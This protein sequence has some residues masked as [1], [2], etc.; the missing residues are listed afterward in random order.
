M[1][2]TTRRFR[3]PRGAAA[4]LACAWEATAPKPGNVHPGRD[5]ADVSYADFI[6][7]AV[8][9]GP[10][11][12]R[13]AEV[14]IGPTVL[15]AVRAT[16]EAVGTN[17]NLGTLLLLAPLAAVPD[18][19]PWTDGIGG[20][21]AR[22]TS[23]DTR[24][25][26]E[27]IRV[28]GAGGLG[29]AQ[30]ADVFGDVP[31]NLSLVEAMRLAADRD[32]VARQ[33]T[34]SFADVLAGPAAW[35]EEGVSRG[36]SLSA[37]IVQAHVRQLA[38]CG[39]SLI[40]RKCGLQTSEQARHR[41]AAVLAVGSPDDGAYERAVSELDVWLRADGHRRNPGTTADLLAAGLF[42]LLREGR[43]DWTKIAWL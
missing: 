13:A 6:S 19:V 8:V 4:T 33:Y 10:I 35:I 16:R 36:W 3:I 42:V 9:I 12:E 34:N 32:L 20:V 18:D 26:Y 2:T 11:V 7:S 38:A 30:E 43:L 27:A 41:A 23:D 22:L 31:A 5:F 1:S 15:A 14:G 21:L 40:G 37:A 17:T 24:G 39:D 25:V 28:S 29:R